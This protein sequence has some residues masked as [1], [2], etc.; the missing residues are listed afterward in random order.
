MF[1]ERTNWNL[2][3]NAL[4]RALAEARASGREILDLTRSNPTECGLLADADALFGALTQPDILQYAPEP[5]GL[6]AART[7]VCRYY[8]DL[9]AP[10]RP[11]RLVLTA[12]T[13]EGYSFLFGLLCNAG[14]EV[15]VPAP[16]YPLFEFLADLCDVRLVPYPL[17]YDHGWQIDL[18][19]L[20]AAA[21]QRTRA[22]IVVHPNNPTGQYVAAMERA[23]LNTFCAQRRLALI[24]DEVFLDFPIEG[25][26]AES[27]VANAETLTFTLSGLSKL[28][29]LPQMKLAWIAAS[30]P[31]REVAAALERLEVIADAY[32]S[33]GTPVQVAAARLLDGGAEFRAR[34]TARV[35]TNLKELDALLAEQTACA[36]L[37]CDAGWAAVLR[38]PATQSDEELA[39]RLVREQ[40]VLVH[41]G[42]FYN[43]AQAG[44]LVVSL[45]T[46]ERQFAKGMRRV[47]AHFAG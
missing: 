32:L 33:V 13:S 45:L 19:G 39:I 30:G 26:R 3:E 41:P 16:G 6:P 38:A 31:E 15:L 10:V 44:Y 37:R 27:F 18:A 17:L 42:H 35:R 36:R 28:C 12:G 43:F 34:A 46:P 25:A 14:D 47:L 4:S 9:G 29:G 24:A 1:S 11:E 5:R 23:Q 8:A 22:V 40:G 21:T 20:A 7:A 2:E